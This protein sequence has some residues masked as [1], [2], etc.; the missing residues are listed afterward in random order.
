VEE[1]TPFEGEMNIQY[2]LVGDY[3]IS[4]G[5]SSISRDP[6]AYCAD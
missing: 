3:V 6:R 5:K 1:E 2:N 4:D